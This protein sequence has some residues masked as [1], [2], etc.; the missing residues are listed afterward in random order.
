MRIRVPCTRVKQ[1]KSNAPEFIING[2][3][4]QDIVK[5][6]KSELK[7]PDAFNSIHI[8]PYK[9]W[10]CPH[11]G[12]DS[13]R[14]YSE[15]YN[16]DAMLQA[17]TKMRD[18]LSLVGQEDNL[19]TFIIAALLYSNSTHLASFE[20]HLSGRSTSFSAPSQNTPVQNLHLLLHTTLHTSPQYVVTLT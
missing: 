8:A 20:A 18:D 4:Y 7:D 9:E 10:W 12:E 11:P 15:I 6:I 3:L 14:V 5:V 19:E 17:D 1:K 16:S 13:I 2:I